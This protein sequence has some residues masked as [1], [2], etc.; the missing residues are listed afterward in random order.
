MAQRKTKE[1]FIQD[2]QSVHG[3]KYNYSRVEYVSAKTKV[4]IIC[5]IHGLFWQTPSDHLR[6]K[7]CFGCGGNPRLGTAQFIENAKKVHGDK[8][9][10]SLTK[11]VNAYTKVKIICPFHGLFEQTSNAHARGQRCPHCAG[12][13]R[14]N[15]DAFIE[16]SRQKH[17]DKYDYSL[18]EYCNNRSKV[19]IVCP[20]HGVFEQTTKDH[21]RGKGCSD[22]ADYSFAMD[23]NSILY[24]LRFQKD[25]AQF[26][27]IG[28]TNRTLQQRFGGDLRYVTDR[29]EWRFSQGKDA[30]TIEQSVLKW[31]AKYKIK[32]GLFSLLSHGGDTECFISSVPVAKVIKFIETEIEQQKT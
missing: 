31:L 3:D 20:V 12:V 22:C 28:V 1:Q 19:K 27:K 25:F 30:Y 14:S 24:F 10:Y 13:A 5:R 18:V 17:G 23:K 7:G 26:W 2:A 32:K 6:G 4:G 8:Y 21:L 15:K 29:N 9:D 16:R 11:Y